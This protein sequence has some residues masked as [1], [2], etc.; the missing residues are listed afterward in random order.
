MRA[1]AAIANGI[2]SI[3]I[4]DHEFP[5]W[6]LIEN[7]R[8]NAGM[9]IAALLQAR[10]VVHNGSAGGNIYIPPLLLLIERHDIIA[11]EKPKAFRADFLVIITG[12]GQWKLRNQR[13]Q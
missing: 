12:Q 3:A 13:Q 8:A 9:P 1:F 7:A 6:R 10:K 2:N 5:G 11:P 4:A